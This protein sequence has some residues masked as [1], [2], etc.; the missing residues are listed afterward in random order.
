MFAVIIGGIYK[1]IFT[2]SEAAGVGAFIVLLY[3]L[4]SRNLTWKKF[5]LAIT[6]AGSTA[7]MTFIILIGAMVM[8]I[9]WPYRVCPWLV[10]LDRQP[11]SISYRG[12]C[13]HYSGLFHS[14][15]LYGQ[16]VHPD[17]DRADHFPII[18]SW[19]LIPSGL[20]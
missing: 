19:A 4:I 5:T 11:G 7:A 20:G 6:E 2:A 13:L 15:L 3:G 12:I 10:Q 8:I 14:G 16:H 17:P 1:G 9:S 18:T